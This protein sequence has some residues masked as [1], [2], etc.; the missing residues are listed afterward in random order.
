MVYCSNK[1]ADFPHPLAT[2]LGGMFYGVV[3]NSLDLGTAQH[4]VGG[5]FW[6]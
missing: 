4:L 2:A 5:G 1:F 6:R 3:I